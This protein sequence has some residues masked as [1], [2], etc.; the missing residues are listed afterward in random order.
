MNSEIII[1]QNTDGK[2]KIDVRLEDETVWLTQAQMAHLFGKDKRTICE[3][4]GNV[5][6]RVLDEN[7]VVRKFRITTQYCAI[8]EQ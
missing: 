5:L 3:H 8:A 6:K 1:Y 2:I 7:V 4:I